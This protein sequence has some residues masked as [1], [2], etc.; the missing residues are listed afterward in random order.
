M[1]AESQGL[2]P[3]FLFIPRLC[4]SCLPE[5]FT[6][7]FCPVSQKYFFFLPNGKVQLRQGRILLYL[8]EGLLR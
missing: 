4:L 3:L 7:Y 5:N 8:P 6:Y 2:R 1:E